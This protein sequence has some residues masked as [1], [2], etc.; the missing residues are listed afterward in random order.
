MRSLRAKPE[1]ATIRSSCRRAACCSEFNWGHGLEN[2]ACFHCRARVL[3]PLLTHTGLS[4]LT[5]GPHATGEGPSSPRLPDGTIIGDIRPKPNC[6]VYVWIGL[7]ANGT[8]VNAE[9]VSAEGAPGSVAGLLQIRARVPDQILLGPE[10]P[11]TILK[12]EGGWTESYP[13]LLWRC[14]KPILSAAFDLIRQVNRSGAH[15]PRPSPGAG[16]T[17]RRILMSLSPSRQ[18]SGRS[19]VKLANWIICGSC[20]TNQHGYGNLD[21]YRRSGSCQCQRSWF[22]VHSDFGCPDCDVS[23]I[24]FCGFTASKDFRELRSDS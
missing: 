24:A 2:T 1:L 15:L 11:M 5:S 8:G 19:R 12:C 7:D 9:V 13:P 23:A 14:A 10:A 22:G 18:H 16:S 20:C 4:F 3:H 17:K 21:R 6:D